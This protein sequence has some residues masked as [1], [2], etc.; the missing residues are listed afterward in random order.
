MD[1]MQVAKVTVTITSTVLIVDMP[2]S[3]LN[4]QGMGTQAKKEQCDKAHA[5]SAPAVGI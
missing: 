5:F 3:S 4:S 1:I 2:P